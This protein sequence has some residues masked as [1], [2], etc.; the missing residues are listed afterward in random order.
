[1]SIF[2]QGKAPDKKGVFH[3]FFQNTIL[4]NYFNIREGSMGLFS[5]VGCIFLNRANI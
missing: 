2:F 4:Y 1:M 5:P 3:I